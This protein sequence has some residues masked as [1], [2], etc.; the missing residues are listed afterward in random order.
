MMAA[1]LAGWD[2]RAAGGG[3]PPPY[4]HCRRARC[5]PQ[6]C[7]RRRL[8]HPASHT[9]TLLLPPPSQTRAAKD[10]SVG[11]ILNVAALLY[12]AISNP[13]YSSLNFLSAFMLDRKL[14]LREQ[15][16]GMYRPTVYLAWKMVDE[17]VLNLVLVT[18]MVRAAAIGDLDAIL[19]LRR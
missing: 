13:A 1:A 19:T 2:W 5:P 14:Y 3:L 18:V 4:Q 11:N 16:D 6:P 10:F 12:L 17:L 15:A 8:A 9:H 7:P